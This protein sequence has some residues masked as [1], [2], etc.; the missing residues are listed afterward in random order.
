MANTPRLLT[1]DGRTQPLT[2]WSKE[3][4]I[5]A[6]TIVSRLNGLGWTV[7]RALTAPVNRRFR[8]AGRPRKNDDRPC[9]AMRRHKASGQAIAEWLR[10]GERHTVY[11]GAWGSGEA[12]TA[13]RRFQTEWAAGAHRARTAGGDVFVADVVVRWLDHCERTYRKRGK[14]TS[15]VHCNRV[16]LGMVVETYGDAEAAA[17]DCNRLEVVRSAMIAKGWARK[18]INKHVARVQRCFSW[19]VTR[20]LVPASVADALRHLKPLQAGRTAAAEPK[21]RRPVGRGDL[22]KTL[23]HLHPNPRRRAVL[24]AMIRV[25]L[26]TGMRPGEVCSMRPEDLDR[27][28]REWCYRPADGGKTFH[29]EKARKVWIGP[30]AQKVLAP[31]LAAAEPGQPVFRFPPWW[32]GA[33]WSRISVARYRNRIRLACK[34]AGVPVWTPHRLRHTRATELMR[35][36]EDDEKVAAAIGDTAEVARQVYVEDPG[37]AVAKRIARETG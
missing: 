11:L 24:E 4:G 3:T 8:R 15:E 7:A 17:F 35:V 5:P 22:D 19:A 10:H 13:Y 21:P 12:R 23:P 1:H 34:A 2:A 36:Y 14:A 28:G 33:A 9:P 29:L 26:L 31:F 16:A 37:D 32:S 30:E 18:T 27:S 25:E 20:G 6:S